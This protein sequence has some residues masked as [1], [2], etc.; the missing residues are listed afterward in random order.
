M[1]KKKTIL[2]RLTTIFW[3][4]AMFLLVGYLPTFFLKSP[5]VSM[6]VSAALVSPFAAAA[7][8]YRRALL[9]GVLLGVL[10]G[11]GINSAM[12]NLHRYRALAGDD[13]QRLMYTVLGCTVFM[14]AAAA[15]LFQ[16]TGRRR[17]L[18]I[19]RRRRGIHE[20]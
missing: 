13:M 17:K 14:C 4:G 16:F 9:R 8:S 1:A 7:E 10:A 18:R 11:L 19:E 15:M 6:G 5:V 20:S 2:K 12:L 3:V